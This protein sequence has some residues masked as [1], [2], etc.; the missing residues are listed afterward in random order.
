MAKGQEIKHDYEAELLRVINENGIKFFDHSFGYTT[1]CR[2]TAYKHGLDKIDAI[3][4]AI[5]KNKVEAKNKMIG[6]WVDSD[7][8]TLQIAA[9]RLM[10]DTEEHQKLNQSYIDHTSKGNTIKIDW[11]E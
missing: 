9:Y 4:D 7:N 3:K 10:S 5:D 11:R 6:K 2:A 1:F 8:P